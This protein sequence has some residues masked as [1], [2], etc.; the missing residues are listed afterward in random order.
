M[1]ISNR[2]MLFL[3]IAVFFITG[4]FEETAKLI[5]DNGIH[6]PSMHF[7]QSVAID[8][9]YAIVGTPYAYNSYDI[10]VGSVTFYWRENGDW[11]TFP[12]REAPSD[13]KNNDHFGNSVGI[14]GDAAIIGACRADNCAGITYIYN[15][16]SY[17][18]NDNRWGAREKLIASDR[19]SNDFFGVAVDIS[20][21]YAVVGAYMDDNYRGADVGAAYVFFRNGRVWQEQ[22]KLIAPD[23]SSSSYFGY[24]VA[25]SGDYIAIGAPSD[26]NTRG[27]DAGS[28][29]IFKRSGSVWNLQDKLVASDGASGDRFGYSVDINNNHAIAGSMLND[30]ANGASAGCAYFFVLSDRWSQASKLTAVDG[31]MN[32][33]FGRSVSISDYYAAV[34]APNNDGAGNNAGAVYMYLLNNN[35]LSYMEKRTASDADAADLFGYSVAVDNNY[36]VFGS[37]FDDNENGVD[38]GAAYIF[39]AQTIDDLG[40]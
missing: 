35:T 5:D 12:E 25:I 17:N 26:D 10:A 23:G 33:Q 2:S 8:G 39:E 32:D 38:A 24:S 1:S 34:G 28:M 30:N 3:L 15:R 4:C 14:S 18:N 29:Y 7:S 20:G 6:Y 37:R 27:K 16:F 9:D 40:L 36:A 31:F 19:A 11:T 22:Y 21:N 13:L